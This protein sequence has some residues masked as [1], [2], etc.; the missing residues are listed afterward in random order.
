MMTALLHQ[1]FFTKLS[2]PLFGPGE[3]GEWKQ[4]SVWAQIEREGEKGNI[5]GLIQEMRGNGYAQ[6]ASYGEDIMSG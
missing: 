6:L 1:N 5:M 3:W 2:G 4:A